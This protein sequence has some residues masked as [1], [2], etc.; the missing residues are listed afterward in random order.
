MRMGRLHI[1]LISGLSIA[2]LA[3]IGVMIHQYGELTEVRQQRDTLSQTLN[4]TQQAL[5]K[6][7]LRLESAL[8]KPPKLPNKDKT[9]IAKR[10]ATIK[11]L[12]SQLSAA[13]SSLSELRERLTNT[14]EENAKALASANKHS[15]QLRS[16]LQARMGD[17]Q[18]E[19]DS[20]Q[21]S[22]KKSQKRI[23]DLQKQNAKLSADNTKGSR[24]MDERRHILANLQDLDQRRESYLRSITQRCQNI[25]SQFRT[26][27]GMLD[28]NRGQDSKA[29]SGAALDLLQNALTST[30]NDLQHL[31]QLSAQVYRLEKKLSKL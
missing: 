1:A 24:R 27:S 16:N 14:S 2:L 5:N 23:A 31:N 21:A 30:D 10:N 7:Q 8:R 28:S 6:S 17:L 12:T 13:Q 15:Q 4:E 3:S 26:M 9:I 18:K 29:F 22:I 25:T 20:A 11:K 19:L